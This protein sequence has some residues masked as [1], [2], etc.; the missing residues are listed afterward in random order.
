MKRNVSKIIVIVAI[1]IILSIMGTLTCEAVSKNNVITSDV[2]T[3]ISEMT[4]EELKENLNNLM[5]T[6]NSEG[7]NKSLISE[8]IN[9]YKEASEKYTNNQIAEMLEESKTV[10][11]KNNIN[12]ESIDS[13]TKVLKG[14]D[15]A[16]LNTII[17]SINIDDLVTKISR[18][19]ELQSIVAEIAKNMG[20]TQTVS[21]LVDIAL[22]ATIVRNILIIFIILFIYRTLLRCIIYKKAGKHAWAPFIPIYRNIVM[23]KI[24]GMNPWWL[25]LLLVPVIGWIILILVSI[26]SK[27]LLAEKFGKGVAFSFGLWILAP[28]FETI[29]VFSKSIKYIKK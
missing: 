27:F 2:K 29:I 10:L 8:G 12:T 17:E 16:Q 28:I 5:L 1:T 14:I 19:E 22:S 23:L 11:E 6:I 7:L 13:I 4:Q 21:L 25:L 3:E 26:A 18:G 15:S 9:M 24:C 20:A